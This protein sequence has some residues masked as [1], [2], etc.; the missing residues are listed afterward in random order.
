MNRPD[1]ARVGEIIAKIAAEE[2]LPRFRNL[3]PGETWDKRPGSVVT[4]ADQKAE[5][6]LAHA[7]VEHVPGS[8]VVGEESSERDPMIFER[9]LGDN[10]VWLIDPIDGTSNY[11]AGKTEF[12]VMIAFVAKGE[13][14]AGWIYRPT[15]GECT[16]AEAGEGAYRD[17]TRLRVATSLPVSGMRGFLGARLRRDKALCAQFGTVINSS[18]CGIE[19]LA[20]VGGNLHFAHYRRLKPW[21][22]A[23]GELI[24]R[25]AGGYSAFLDGEPYR[26]WRAE[27]RNGLLLAPDSASWHALTT[28]IVPALDQLN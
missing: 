14:R 19:Y 16:T 1:I 26:P 18:C 24:H 28:V 5:E 13:T 23:A 7:L 27:T 25:E 20:L 15:T 12:V 6:R 21:D 4:I 17:G 10:A 8:L 3:N 11:A 22:H 9:N 2:I